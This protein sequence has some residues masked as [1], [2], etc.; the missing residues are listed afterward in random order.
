MGVGKS[1]QWSVFNLNVRC[2]G[3][4]VIRRGVAS[5]AVVVF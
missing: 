5:S 2:G 4:V 1:G 3:G